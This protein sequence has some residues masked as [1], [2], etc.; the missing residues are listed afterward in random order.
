MLNTVLNICLG[1]E[2]E[3]NIANKLTEKAIHNRVLYINA[4]IAL[5]YS[6]SRPISSSSFS[7]GRNK[8][9]FISSDLINIEILN[10]CALPI[11]NHFNIF[12]M[13][14]N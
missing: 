13:K 7:Y 12:S 1:I 10:G 9:L 4:P 14:V 5:R 2:E 6:I 3:L 11:K 8:S